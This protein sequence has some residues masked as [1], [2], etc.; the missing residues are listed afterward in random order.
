[1]FTAPNLN[2]FS[3]KDKIEDMVVYEKTTMKDIYDLYNNFKSKGKEILPT[4][5]NFFDCNNNYFSFQIGDVTGYDI[6]NKPIEITFE[7]KKI[8]LI[9]DPQVRYIKEKYKIDL[10]ICQDDKSNDYL[11]LYTLNN[12]KNHKY[13]L[14]SSSNFKIFSNQEEI[15]EYMKKYVGKFIGQVFESPKDFEKNYQYY[16]NY[17]KKFKNDFKFLIFDNNNSSSRYELAKEIT[18]WEFGICRYYFGSSGKGKS[19]TLIGALKYGKKD[20]SLGALYINCKTMRV[21]FKDN[22]IGVMKQ[23][24]IDEIVFLLRNKYKEYLECCEKIKNFMF[25]NEYDF[26]SLIQDILEYIKNIKDYHFIIAFDQ[27][28]NENDIYSRLREIKSD[29]LNNKNF[30]LIV[31]SSM[32]ESDIRNIKIENLF[33]NDNENK[34]NNSNNPF[35]IKE[36]C[37]DFYTGFNQEEKDIFLLLGKTMKAYNEIIQIKYNNCIDQSLDDYIN[38]KR[39]KIKFKFFCFY[40]GAKR[41]KDLFYRDDI[42]I[43]FGDHMQKILSFVPKQEYSSEDLKKIIDNIPFRFFNIENKNNNYII[44][45]SYPLIEQILI[46]IYKELIL[47]NS[48]S[49]LKH[50]TKDSGA[51]GCIFEYAVINY[52][53]EKSKSNDKKLFNYF[54]IGKNLVVKKFVIN[55]NESAENLL[56]KKQTLDI[57]YDYVIEQEIFN[58]KTLDFILIRFINANPYVYGFKVSVFIKQIYNIKDL[59]KSYEIMK[60][61]LKNYFGL[62]FKVEN[63]F[64]GYIFNYEDVNSDRY[65]RMLK[66]C[67]D[68]SLKYCFFDPKNKK[69]VNKQGNSITNIKDIISSVFIENKDKPIT[70]L[71]DFVYYPLQI[72]YSYI[73]I[74]LNHFQYNTVTNIVKKR[75][76]NAHYWQIVKCSNYDEFAISYIYRKNFF[77]LCYNFPYI[78]VVFFQPYKVYNLLSN[79]EVEESTVDNNAEIYICEIIRNQNII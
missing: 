66:N 60:I 25:K 26:W 69:F 5:V 47:K 15:N 21:L 23:I 43:D 10:I 42:I 71:D 9:C 49:V 76:G 27:Y 28:N 14:A 64:F 68:E 4:N 39:K 62:N 51:F 24:L 36:I 1:M 77:Y 32:N 54:N 22:K 18:N 79:G 45:F 61:L 30:R 44:T 35:E 63:M 37:S 46:D 70:N 73:N 17:N 65:T 58:G 41:R 55:K 40:E 16:F 52:I 7:N 20:E 33:Y 57:Q 67:E 74:D 29:L 56:F 78:K 8:D 31:F 59:R 13:T 75:W 11:S 12:H 53:V 72:N 48:F 34:N 3:L 50:I 6:L 38:E 2:S 19:I